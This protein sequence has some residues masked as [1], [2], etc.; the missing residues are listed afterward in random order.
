MSW[1]AVVVRGLHWSM[2]YSTKLATTASNTCSSIPPPDPKCSTD[3]LDSAVPSPHFDSISA[4]MAPEGP[5]PMN[6]TEHEAPMRDEPTEDR[7][8][9]IDPATRA[10][11]IVEALPYIQ[12]FAGRTIVVKY[13]GNAMVEADLA[14]DFAADIVLLQAI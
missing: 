10:A 11:V 9:G 3:G 12:Q 14:R 6:M 8:T 1:H 2:D 7:S 13:G 5:K 4:A